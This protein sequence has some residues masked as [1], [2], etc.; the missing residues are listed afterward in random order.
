MGENAQPPLGFAEG[1]SY[2]ISIENILRFA[3][4][5]AILKV[6]SFEREERI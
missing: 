1:L 6:T 5:F 3:E 2:F 4:V